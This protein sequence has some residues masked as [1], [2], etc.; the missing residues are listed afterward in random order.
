VA[1][2]RRAGFARPLA[3]TGADRLLWR[4]GASTRR[5]GSFLREAVAF[6]GLPGD[7]IFL[8]PRG[9]L[10]GGEIPVVH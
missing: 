10:A 8:A 9:A 5:K 6:Q 3:G 7:Q 2:R 1:R 4:E